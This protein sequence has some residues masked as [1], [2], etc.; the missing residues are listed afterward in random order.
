MSGSKKV[1]K[2]NSF[3]N[4]NFHEAVQDDGVERENVFQ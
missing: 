2:V 4:K 3:R 1:L